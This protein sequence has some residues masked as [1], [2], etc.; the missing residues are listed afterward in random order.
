MYLLR[1]FITLL[2][3][4]SNCTTPSLPLSSCILGFSSRNGSSLLNLSSLIWSLL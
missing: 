1:F 4:F 2:V 3:T